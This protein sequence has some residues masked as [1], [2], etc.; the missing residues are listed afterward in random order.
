M[1]KYITVLDSDLHMDYWKA[2]QWD[3]S[4]DSIR[5]NP[6]YTAG[7]NLNS[8]KK[9]GDTLLEEKIIFEVYTNLEGTGKIIQIAPETKA[10][11]D[12]AEN[13]TPIK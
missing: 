7:T 8:L 4:L 3:D 1:P 10:A 13:K 6:N 12:I 11:L 5:G 2:V 9:S